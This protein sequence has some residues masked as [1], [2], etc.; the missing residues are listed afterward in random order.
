MQKYTNFGEGCNT[1][2]AMLVDDVYERQARHLSR[3][4]GIAYHVAVAAVR[5]NMQVKEACHG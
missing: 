2:V 1:P 3:T 4:I 5:A